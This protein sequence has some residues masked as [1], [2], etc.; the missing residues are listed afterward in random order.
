MKRAAVIGILAVILA[1][2]GSATSSPASSPGTT[3]M[4]VP[5][6]WKTFA[7]RKAKISVPSDWVVH[8]TASCVDRTAPGTLELGRPTIL[9]NCEA[10]ARDATTVTLSPLP[11]GGVNRSFVCPPMKLNGLKVYFGP[12]TTSNPA[13]IVVYLIPSLGVGAVGTGTSTENVTGPGEGTIV[14]RVLHTLRKG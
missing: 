2:C 11:A 6:G 10:V 9:S 12:C 8:R 1:A 5:H 4:S 7:Y 3:T 13:G 14:G